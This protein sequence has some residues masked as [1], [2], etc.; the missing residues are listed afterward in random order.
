MTCFL[1]DEPQKAKFKYL[2]LLRLAE[3]RAVLK[4]ESTLPGEGAEK[5]LRIF[6]II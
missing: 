1:L 3:D 2:L 5:N 6:I 4:E